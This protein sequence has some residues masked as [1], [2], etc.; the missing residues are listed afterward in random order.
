MLVGNQQAHG[1]IFQIDDRSDIPF[2][3]TVDA[4]QI[5][6]RLVKGVPVVRDLYAANVGRVVKALDMVF[7]PEYAGPSRGFVETNPLEHTQSVVQG[8]GQDV[9]LSILPVHH[10]TVHPYF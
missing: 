10:L 9:D 1:P 4:H 5:D 7:E 8:V 2:R 3:K 6:V